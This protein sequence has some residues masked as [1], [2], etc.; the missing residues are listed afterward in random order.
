MFQNF[1]IFCEEQ[2]NLDTGRVSINNFHFQRAEFIAYLIYLKKP[3]IH[4]F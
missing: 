4:Y 2:N 3:E 1:Q